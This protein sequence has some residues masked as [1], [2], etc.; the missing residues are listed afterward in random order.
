MAGELIEKGNDRFQVKV[1]LGKDDS[2]KRKFHCKTIKGKKEAEKYLRKILHQKD[3]GEIVDSRKVTIAEHMES[4]LETV[5]KHRVRQA[6]YLDYKDRVRLYIT[7]VIGNVKLSNLKPKMIQALYSD[8]IGKGLSSRSV[9]Y[10][11]TILRNSLQQAVKWELLNKNPADLVSDELPNNKREEM[12]V[13]TKEQA[14]SFLES[15]AYS[16]MKAFFCLLLC[17][18]MRPSEALG[19]KWSDVDFENNR[20][21]INRTLTRYRKGGWSLEEPKTSRSRRTI[22]LPKTAMKDL[23][24]HEKEQLAEILKAEPG[25]YNKHDFVFAANNG[26]PLSNRNVLMRHFKPILE[27][28]GLPDIRLYDLR[29][30]CATLLLAAGE[31]PKIVSER[32]GHAS[33]T[34][35]LDTYSHVLP[36]MQEASAAK[37][38]GMLFGNAT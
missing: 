5:V 20:I 17:S 24:D 2:G 27:K 13:L 37:L 3:S 22:P 32:L 30:T 34:L 6:T 35:T 15:T 11:H 12:K 29:H 36:D 10:V 26:E 21:T 4:W 28:A 1:Y 7:P 18:G 14:A 38:E 8:M 33:I 25:K 16:P 19:L 31:N 23:K 9:R